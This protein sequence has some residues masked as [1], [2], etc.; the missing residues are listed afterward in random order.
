MQQLAS[1]DRTMRVNRLVAVDGAS[2]MRER[3]TSA[4]LVHK[5]EC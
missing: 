2:F 4:T 3:S 5:R 1:L